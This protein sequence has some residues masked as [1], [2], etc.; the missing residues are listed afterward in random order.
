M[1]I[2]DSR[3]SR[4]MA[5]GNVSRSP[6]TW[7][8]NLIRQVR[9]A[10][11]ALARRVG[12]QVTANDVYGNRLAM[13]EHVIDLAKSVFGL[14]VAQ[15]RH[16]HLICGC[17]ITR[18]DGIKKATREGIVVFRNHFLKQSLVIAACEQ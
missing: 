3:R 9:G 13:G 11:R 15:R 16:K 1:R 6:R 4:L 2:Y 10:R 5:D 12:K 14:R 17:V 7:E 18:P 8:V